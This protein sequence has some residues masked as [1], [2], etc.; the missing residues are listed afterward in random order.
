ML[1]E[2]LEIKNINAKKTHTHFLTS[3]FIRVPQTVTASRYSPQ[4]FLRAFEISPTVT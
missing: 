1:I 4:I 2:V 3:L